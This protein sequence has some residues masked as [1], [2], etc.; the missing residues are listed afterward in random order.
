MPGTAP[1]MAVP[2]VLKDGADSIGVNGALARVYISIGSDHE[3]W[4]KHFNLLA[5]GKKQSPYSIDF[6]RKNSSYFRATLDRLDNLAKFFV[7]ASKPHPLARAPGGDAFLQDSAATVARGRQVFAENCAACHVSPNK[8]PVPPEQAACGSPDWKDWARSPAFKSKMLE[9]MRE[10]DFLDGNYLSTDQPC[11]DSMIGTNLCAALASNAVRGHIW[12]NF[13]SETYK[14]RPAIGIVGINDPFT[15][16]MRPYVVA[17]GGRGYQRVPS[18]VSI[19]ASAPYLHNNSVGTFTGDPSVAGRMKAFEDGMEKL[20]WPEKR[21]GMASIYR[22]TQESSL[23]IERSWVPALLFKALAKKF[24][25]PGDRNVVRIGPIPKGTPVNLL[26]NIDLEPT[27]NPVKLIDFAEAVFKV[28]AAL[29]DIQKKE[30]D[31]AAAAARL[32]ELGP[33]L[34]K[35]S[36]CPDFVTDRG[37]LFGTGLPDA[38]KRALIVYLKRL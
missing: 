31:E 22:T 24:A 14:H 18:L 6:A 34:L 25:L 19:W 1:E 32:K 4:I 29:N 5:G 10:P 15:G 21:L 35:L 38:D 28:N 7:A 30:L 12:D 3:A 37:H 26:A 11:P 8:L 27:F 17:G 9:R 16:E 13:S 23:Y 33:T 20:L 36:K 2:H